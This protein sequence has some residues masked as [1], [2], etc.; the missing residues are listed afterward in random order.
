VPWPP[1]APHEQ[2]WALL[3]SAY[4]RSHCLGVT[5]CPPAIV[6]PYVIEKHPI[7]QAAVFLVLKLILLPPYVYG[8]AYLDDAT[9]QRTL[10]WKQQLLSKY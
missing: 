7:A 5:L 6:D 2:G 4:S 10:R 3:L 9:R 8:R 1:A